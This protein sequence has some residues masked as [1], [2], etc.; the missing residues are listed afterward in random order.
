MKKNENAP[1]VQTDLPTPC[2][3]IPLPVVGMRVGWRKSPAEAGHG[4]K[5]WNGKKIKHSHVAGG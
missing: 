3:W 2:G 4:H 5:S 1:V